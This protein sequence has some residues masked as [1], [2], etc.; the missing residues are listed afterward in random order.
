MNHSFTVDMARALAERL[1]REANEPSDQVRRAFL[2]AY[3]RPPDPPE[4][5]AAVALIEQHGLAAFCRA[6]LNSN[7][8]IYIH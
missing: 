6:I 3:A 7:E 5:R 1:G 8:L 4:Q 2:L